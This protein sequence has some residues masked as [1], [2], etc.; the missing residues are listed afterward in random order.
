MSKVYFDSDGGTHVLNVMWLNG[1]YGVYVDGNLYASADT[2]AEADEVIED[3][4][5]EHDLSTVKPKKR[6]RNTPRSLAK[7]HAE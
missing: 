1:Q 6:K 7:T 2:R 4:V 5:D 3:Y